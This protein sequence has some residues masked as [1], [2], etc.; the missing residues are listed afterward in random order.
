MT[1]LYAFVEAQHDFGSYILGGTTSQGARLEIPTSTLHPY[2]I[3]RLEDDPSYLVGCWAAPSRLNGVQGTFYQCSEPLLLSE[4]P[5]TLSLLGC[6][7]LLGI[8]KRW[9]S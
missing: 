9:Q 1:A 6:A 5:L 8:L 4:S 7:L 2:Q 3:A